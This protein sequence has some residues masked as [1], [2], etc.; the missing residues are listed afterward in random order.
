M[1]SRNIGQTKNCTKKFCKI[2]VEFVCYVQ[3]WI[4]RPSTKLMPSPMLTAM[5]ISF[6]YCYRL[7]VNKLTSSNI[8]LSCLAVR[9][10]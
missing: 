9:V 7:V 6:C 10:T 4:I 8:R 2:F 1:P 3:L 5:C